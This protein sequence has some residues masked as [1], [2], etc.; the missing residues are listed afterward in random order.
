MTLPIEFRRYG[1][2]AASTTPT[3]LMLIAGRRRKAEDASGGE[4]RGARGAEGEDQEDVGLEDRRRLAGEC[5]WTSAQLHAGGLT[6][7]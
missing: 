4:D 7:R 6:G 3:D 1:R 2:P 5:L